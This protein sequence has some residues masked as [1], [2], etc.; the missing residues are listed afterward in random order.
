MQLTATGYRPDPTEQSPWLRRVDFRDAFAWF[1]GPMFVLLTVSIY[2]RLPGP[3]LAV[4]VIGHGFGPLVGILYAKWSERHA[5]RVA[6]RKRSR[7]M[8]RAAQERF[9]LA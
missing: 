1:Y 8:M 5:Q 2:L 7:E 6:R 3:A 4:I 9:G